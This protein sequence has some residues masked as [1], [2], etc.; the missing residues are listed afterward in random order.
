MNELHVGPVKWYVCGIPPPRERRCR[1]PLP[2]RS[3]LSRLSHPLPADRPH[4]PFASHMLIVKYPLL[5]L[6]GVSASNTNAKIVAAV[7]NN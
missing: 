7:E 6:L 2:L 4:S 1:R 5:S 3:F